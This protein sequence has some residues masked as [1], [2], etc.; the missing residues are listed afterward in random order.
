VHLEKLAVMNQENVWQFTFNHM[1][2]FD[3]ARR[4]R[5]LAACGLEQ[6][7]FPGNRPS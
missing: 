5:T 7:H 2:Q 4:L 1:N 6:A 3:A